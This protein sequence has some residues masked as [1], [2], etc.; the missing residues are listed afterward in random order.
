MNTKK[1]SKK[2]ELKKSRIMNFL[3]LPKKK[4]KNAGN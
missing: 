4:R 1:H 2:L 3:I